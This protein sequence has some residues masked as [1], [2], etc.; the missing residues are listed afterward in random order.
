VFQSHAY[1]SEERIFDELLRVL[2][3]DSTYED[4]LVEKN[5]CIRI[6]YE[7]DF[8]MDILP[9]SLARGNDEEVIIFQDRKLN[10][11]FK[12]NPKGFA[13]WFLGKANSLTSSVLQRFRNAM[14]ESKVDTEPLPEDLYTKTPL[15]RSVQLTKRYRDIYFKNRD[16]PVSSIVIT[17]IFGQFY[18]G[19]DNIYET[20]DKVLERIKNEYNQSIKSHKVFKIF[21]PVIPEEEFTDSWTA[22]H[23]ESFFNF[24]TDY[25]V[26][27]QELKQSFERSNPYYKELFGHHVYRQSLIEKEKAFANTSDDEITKALGLIL[28]GEARSD[29]RGRIDSIIGEKHEEHSNFGG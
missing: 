29:S 11:L 3:A 12:G 14:I 5:R 16:Y 22:K 23:Y 25:Y 15:Q 6:D 27:W 28:T 24:I 4:K 26:L 17:T 2:K 8:H 9:A 20:I 21:N 18:G 10:S 13:T 19:E 1:F 7:G